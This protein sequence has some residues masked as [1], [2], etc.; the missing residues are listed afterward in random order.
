[1]NAANYHNEAFVNS[2]RSGQKYSEVPRSKA[3]SSSWPAY[4]YANRE[5]IGSP[6]RL[7][8]VT[9]MR[10]FWQHHAEKLSLTQIKHLAQISEYLCDWPLLSQVSQ[11]GISKDSCKSGN[12]VRQQI[13]ALWHT[14]DYQRAQDSTLSELLLQPSNTWAFGLHRALLSWQDYCHRQCLGSFDALEQDNL[15]L[16]PLGHHHCESFL[17]QYLDSDIPQWCSLPVFETTDHWHHWL[18][19]ELDTPN[20]RT[21]AVLH[22]NWGL[23]GSVSLTQLNDTGF[24]YYWIGSDFQGQGYGPA[25][26]EMLLRHA[27][28]NIGLSCCF[29]KAYH[30]NYRSLRGLAKL[31]FVEIPFRVKAPRQ[32]EKLFY[33]GPHKRLDEL[34]KDVLELLDFLQSE[35]EIE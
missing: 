3:Y 27:S 21:F 24:F 32:R 30:D 10:G 31:G 34:R 4:V 23:I 22:R 11:H 1:M 5:K 18:R 29:A 20:K 13:Q 14:L 2:H 19:G 6:D 26:V 12:L 17:W 7:A 16:E 15:M 8:V 33:L 9:N 25:A 28:Q 35:V